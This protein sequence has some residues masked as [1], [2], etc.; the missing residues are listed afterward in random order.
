MTMDIK[1][2]ITQQWL[3][4]CTEDHNWTLDSAMQKWWKNNHHGTGFKLRLT[5]S[6]MNFVVD[7]LKLPTWE[8]SILPMIINHSDISQSEL[9]SLLVLDRY[10]P[11]PYF[12]SVEQ[13]TIKK[14]MIL[15]LLDSK[16][17]MSFVMFGG[18]GAYLKNLVRQYQN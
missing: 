15:S 3:D 6:G 18:F 12:L 4:A 17:A 11:C 9:R 10:C 5:R 2:Q 14:A 7:S 1:K 13:F 8:F 16:E